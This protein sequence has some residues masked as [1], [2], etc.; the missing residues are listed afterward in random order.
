L[1]RTGCGRPVFDLQ[2]FLAKQRSNLG[3]EDFRQAG[4][5]PIFRTAWKF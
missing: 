3:F 5:G 4:T 1:R 2:I